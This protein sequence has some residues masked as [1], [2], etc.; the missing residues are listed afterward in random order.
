LRDAEGIIEVSDGGGATRT[1]CLHA[2]VCK[3]L[4]V[5]V[6]QPCAAPTLAVGVQQKI[7]DPF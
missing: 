6:K 4:R 1:R 7:F 5:Y 3:W 2:D